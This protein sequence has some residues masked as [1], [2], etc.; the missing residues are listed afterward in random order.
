MHTSAGDACRPG[1][2]AGFDMVL[3]QFCSMLRGFHVTLPL[4]ALDCMVGMCML[5]MLDKWMSAGCVRDGF[6]LAE[7]ATS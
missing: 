5:R 1:Q 2:G 3:L 6:G 4:L 7:L